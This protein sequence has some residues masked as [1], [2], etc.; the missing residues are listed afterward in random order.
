M[1]N[2]NITCRVI[3]PN[4]GR[5]ESRKEIVLFNNAL[6]TLYIYI[7]DVGHMVKDHSMRENQL[8]A[9]CGLFFLISSMVF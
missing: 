1:T 7:Y 2:G 3:N 9:L 5:K 8:P 4:N 6:N